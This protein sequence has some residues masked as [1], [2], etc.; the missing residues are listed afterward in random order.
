MRKVLSILSVLIVLTSCGQ[1][2]NTAAP[3]PVKYLGVTEDRVEQKIVDY[4]GY[5][6]ELP[7]EE[8]QTMMRRLFDNIVADELSD[9]TK[10]AYLK[11]TEI[12]SRYLY[13][14]NS[15]LRDE[16]LYLPFV[17]R[18][19]ASR[20][21]SDDIRPAYEF[22]ARMC[23]LNQR[24]QVVP[25]FQFTDLGSR[26]HSLYDVK[27]RF[28][29]LFFSNPGC[30]ACREIIEV[31][32]SDDLIREGLSS[33][34]ISIVNVYIDDD[35]QAWKEYAV[36]YPKTWLS[37]YDHIHSLRDDGNYYIRAI[38]SV[39]LLD[40]KKAVILKDADLNRLM[41]TLYNSMR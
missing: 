22:E 26:R 13:D 16:D 39:Y 8:G 35:I 25:D 7:I 17:E 20:L 32:D 28:T 34:E 3:G 24:G 1:H 23:A 19:A 15:P 30:E 9:T 37:G 12:V 5:A 33:G 6:M 36:R 27:S 38:P 29:I 14:P 21:T 2:R 40:S 11:L 18:M 10:F 31:L 4:I 41:Y